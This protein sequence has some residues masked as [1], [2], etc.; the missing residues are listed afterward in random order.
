MKTQQS[1][2]RTPAANR[3]VPAI[4]LP[5]LIQKRKQQEAAQ[6]EAR[7]RAA[8]AVEI[9]TPEAPAEVEMAE[10]PASPI[11]PAEE[12]APIETSAEEAAS[13]IIVE[14]PVVNGEEVEEEARSVH[15]E[16]G[17]QTEFLAWLRIQ[18]TSFEEPALDTPTSTTSDN[19]SSGSR[20]AYQMPPPF[21]PANQ[22]QSHPQHNGGYH[23]YV[24]APQ[25]HALNGGSVSNGYSASNRSSPAPLSGG[26]FVPPMYQ[27]PLPQYQQHPG[28]HAP[29]LSNGVHPQHPPNGFAAGSVLPP[30]PGGFTPMTDNF[31]NRG[32]DW[33][34]LRPMHQTYTPQNGYNNA[35]GHSV[36]GTPIQLDGLPPSTPHSVQGSH[37][38][39]NEGVYYP[40]RPH[41]PPG[42]PGV[43][44][45][46]NNATGNQGPSR[47]KFRP[48][49][50]HEIRHPVMPDDYDWATQKIREKF[51]QAEYSD[52]TLNL[53]YTDKRVSP[54]PLPVHGLI[55]D[56]S[57][58]LRL[59]MEGA[60]QH[61]SRDLYLQT[62]DRFVS[63]DGFLLALQRLYCESLLD[64]YVLGDME[65]RSEIQGKEFDPADF[66]L[67]YAASGHLL[68]LASVVVRGVDLACWLLN[69][70]NIERVLE[71][72]IDGGLE[73]QWYKRQAPDIQ[74][75]GATYGPATNKIISEVIRFLVVNLPQ[76]MVT[77]NFS[78]DRAMRDIS[79]NTR[80]P[81]QP[82]TV[83]SA[84]TRSATHNPRLS[85]IKFGDHDE[86]EPVVTEADANILVFYRLLLNL[87][88]HLLTC[89]LERIPSIF[90]G[91][92]DPSVR[93]KFI[94]ELVLQRESRRG[95]VR[96]CSVSNAERQG[97][98]KAWNV[99]GWKE[100]V[101]YDEHEYPYLSRSW[102]GFESEATSSSG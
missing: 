39:F 57:P 6:A 40:A 95:S 23:G 93:S 31:G 87:P 54:M 90:P 50:S 64:H 58:I 33:Y 61:S 88:F 63:T 7:E 29:H 4:P 82:D 81:Q 17:M 59:L 19:Q 75:A 69:F 96:Q 9:P 10:A 73:P 97:N 13:P 68:G 62:S 27:Q 94:L 79:H 38:S 70:N 60:A 100:D 21:V 67:S 84:G 28:Q 71:F 83:D 12:S 98:E 45:Y 43:L 2:M 1:R 30:P 102:V 56:R 101:A 85:G 51:G 99:V 11:I 65:R 15:G 8:A 86:E 44:I 49:G 52:F 35:E 3:V 76:H 46:A 92:S 72:A 78:F 18:L 20:S 14:E 77:E 37:A 5:Y 55:V 36:S 42:P 48:R 89:F 24:A 25:G 26:G 66:A 32:P 47:F 22:Q 41:I 74:Y 80:L 16:A 53:S 34:G 91:W